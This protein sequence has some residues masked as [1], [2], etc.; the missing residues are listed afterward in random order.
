MSLL[1]LM[2]QTCTIYPKTGYSGEGRASLGTGV[3]SICRAQSM[4]KNVR[5]SERETATIDLLLYLPADTDVGLDYKV[6]YNGSDHKMLKIYPTPNGEGV[7]E[8]N[9][10]ECIKWQT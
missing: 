6:T 2:N 1:G 4:N 9:R 10:V 8:F 7:T 3:S 5:I